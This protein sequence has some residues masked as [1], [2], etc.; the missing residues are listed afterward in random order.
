MGEMCRLIRTLNGQRGKTAPNPGSSWG[1][2]TQQIRCLQDAIQDIR[3]QFTTTDTQIIEQN[4]GLAGLQSTLQSAIGGSNQAV[5][6]MIQNTIISMA[7]TD[8]PQPNNQLQTALAQ[9]I[10]EMKGTVDSIKKPTI[11]ATPTLGS[12]TGTWAL[13]ASVLGANGVQ[14]DYI[15]PETL[16]ATVTT[17]A[18]PGHNGVL[19]SEQ[20]S[21]VA[22]APLSTDPLDF[23]AMTAGTLYSGVANSLNIVDPTQSNA[24]NLLTN[25][26]DF[27]DANTANLPDN[28]LALGATVVGTDLKVP[29]GGYFGGNVVEFL[30]DGA[31]L[32]G[33]A[34]TFN[35]PAGTAAILSPN[36]V[37]CVALRTKVNSAPAAGALRVALLDGSNTVIND[38]AAT[39]NSGTVDVTAETASWA[40]H[41]F[42]FRTPAVLP[43]T[44]KIGVSLTTAITATHNLYIDAIAIK[45]ASQFYPGGPFLDAFRG[46]VDAI[47]GDTCSI[48]LANN[49]ATVAIFALMSNLVFNLRGLGL[50]IPSASGNTIN[51]ALVQ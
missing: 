50:Q 35:L 12:N 11:T 46:A 45:Q 5:Q 32:T 40:F 6:T 17:D 30:G 44:V 4:G 51:E 3:L 34:Q 39:P 43:A 27:T 28:W 37:Y 10:S 24:A 2:T 8:T 13:A 15:I 7:Q 21:V 25:S 19:G 42:Y 16:T 48:V 14:N 9:L 29:T 47:I 22:P 41:S 38:A 18:Q 20:I 36:T 23:T 26:A 1:G 49:W 33:I 31:T